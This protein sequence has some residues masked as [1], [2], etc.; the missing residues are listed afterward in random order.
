[1]PGCVGDKVKPVSDFIR[2][3]VALAIET[4]SKVVEVKTV[5]EKE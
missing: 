1:M 4:G 2:G 3:R 5:E